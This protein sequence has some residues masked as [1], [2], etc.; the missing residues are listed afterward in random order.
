MEVAQS[1]LTLWDPL[2][3]SPSG[4]SVHAVLQA[5][6]LEWLA[7]PFSLGSSRPRSPTLQ[8]D[9]LP[10]EPQGK[11]MN[12]GVSSLSLLHGILP[13]Q[14]S[15]QGLLQCRQILYPLSYQGRSHLTERRA[16]TEASHCQGSCEQH[17]VAPFSSIVCVNGLCCCCS[18]CK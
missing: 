6:I 2:D 17:V 5:R 16:Q 10:S 18:D 13:S 7:I 8:A 11:P 12:T 3:C 1:C 15:N 9:S 14:E 4:S